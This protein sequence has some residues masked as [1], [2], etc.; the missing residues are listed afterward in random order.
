M[1]RHQLAQYVKFLWL[2][3]K[4]RL[5]WRRSPSFAANIQGAYRIWAMFTYYRSWVLLECKRKVYTYLQN[6][7]RIYYRNI[8]LMLTAIEVHGSIHHTKKCNV[9]SLFI[10]TS[11]QLSSS[12]D[13]AYYRDCER[14]CILWAHINNCGILTYNPLSQTFWVSMLSWRCEPRR[15]ELRIASKQQ[16]WRLHMA[17]RYRR[18]DP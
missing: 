13:E 9:G 15:Q 16:W 3:E 11:K 1:I 6:F 17:V 4:I 12:G 2:T 14:V 10:V 8:P 18:L 7:Y 5:I